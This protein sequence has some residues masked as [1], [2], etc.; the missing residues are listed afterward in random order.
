MPG[1][2][3]LLKQDLLQLFSSAIHLKTQLITVV[4]TIK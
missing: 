1:T 2:D 4:L 3:R